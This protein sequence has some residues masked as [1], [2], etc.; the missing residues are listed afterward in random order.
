MSDEDTTKV[1]SLPPELRQ[2][3][4]PAKSAYLLVVSTRIGAS[5]GRM[6]K[7][8]REESVIGRSAEA[9]INLQ[10]DGISRRHAKLLR[11]ASGVYELVDL[12][13][14]NGTFVNGQKIATP[15]LLKDGDKI[16]V[17]STTVLVF[18]LQDQLEEQ[19]QKSIYESAT[20]DGLTRIYNKKYLLELLRKEHSYCIRH[21]VPLS[22]VLFDV[23]HFKRVNDTFGHQAGD[24]VLIRIT[25]EILKVIRAEDV[26][27]R[28]GGEE[29]AILLR[30]S[31][32]EQAMVCAE[33]CRRAIELATL[34]FRNSPIKVTISL[35]A[36]TLKDAEYAQPE[37]MVAAADKNLY[38]AKRGGRNKAV[39]GK[40]QP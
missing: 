7:L 9:E 8:E 14:T 34:S 30:E 23:D 12:E 5:T 25:E 17:G 35:G 2:A 10:D 15:H 18:S 38:A 16:Q 19:F 37:D 32:E 29:F 4:Q 20:R 3:Q 24:Q 36:A 21:R 28:Y 31:T 33:R 1:Q 27:A 6:F 26:F 11:A 39:G 40:P 13:S 22:L